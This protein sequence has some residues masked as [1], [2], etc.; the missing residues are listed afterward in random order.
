M[1]TENKS[2]HIYR[3]DPNE[4]KEDM[5]PVEKRKSPRFSIEWEKLKRWIE[6]Q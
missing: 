4:E 1:L 5:R 6:G 2:P 3:E